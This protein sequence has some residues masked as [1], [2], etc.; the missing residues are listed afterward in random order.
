M[1]NDDVEDV[2]VDD[3]VEYTVVVFVDE[4]DNDVDDDVEEVESENDGP[5]DD[6]VREVDDMTVDDGVT[7]L[8]VD[9]GVVDTVLVVVDCDVDAVA[10]S[11]LMNMYAL[12]RTT[13]NLALCGPCTH[14]FLLVLLSF[15]F[16]VLGGILILKRNHEY[17]FTLDINPY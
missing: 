10:E 4:D 1:E 13:N 14:C 7:E 11:T 15:F 16:M 17:L 12:M 3:D 6:D 2:E 9:D 8:V 5:G